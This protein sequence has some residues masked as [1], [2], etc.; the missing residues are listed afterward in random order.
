MILERLSVACWRSILGEVVLGPLE[1]R[2]NLVSAPNGSGK[3]SLFEALQRGIFD[4]HQVSGRSMEEIRPW[5]RDLAPR[6]CIEFSHDGTGYRLTKQFLNQAF[7]RLERREQGRFQPFKQGRRADE[8]VRGLFSDRSPGR[9]LS[10]PEH[11]GLLQVLWAPQ[12]RVALSD[13]S[14]TVVT[15][16]KQALGVQLSA[17][18]GGPIEEEIARRYF[19]FFTRTGKVR[20]GRNAPELV[21]L[22]A[23]LQQLRRQLEQL[24]EQRRA[25]E[26]A[27]LELERQCGLRQQAATEAAGLSRK[28][29]EARQRQK[30]FEQVR[31]ELQNARSRAVAAEAEYRSLEER[32]RRL[33]SATREVKELDGQIGADRQKLELAQEEIACLEK[34]AARRRAR[35]EDLE[36]EKKHL[37]WLE[38]RATMGLRFVRAGD[39]LESLTKRLEQIEKC[40]RKLEVARQQRQGLVAPDRDTLK[41]VRRMVERCSRLEARIQGAMVHLEIDPCRNL[42]V[43]IV[44]GEGDV[45]RA[46]EGRPVTISGPAEVVVEL[47]GLARLRATGPAADLEKQQRDLE[48]TRRELERLTLPYGTADPDKLQQLLFRAEKLDARIAE[49]ERTRSLLLEDGDIQHLRAGIAEYKGLVNGALEEF[50]AWKDSPADPD[51][52]KEEYEEA[53]RAYEKRSTDATAAYEQARREL[54]A[55][56]TG[57][58][59]LMAGLEAKQAERNRA[60]ERLAELGQ[61]GQSLGLLDERRKRLALEW[62]AARA[63]IKDLEKRLQGFGADPGEELEDLERRLELALET[64]RRARDREKTVEGRVS[65]LAGQGI[66]GRIAACQEKISILEDQVERKRLEMDGVALLYRTVNELRSEL[67]ASVARPLEDVASGLMKR[68]G[69]Y[70]A[71]RVRLADDLAPAYIEP[72]LADQPVGLENLSGGENEQ[73]HFVCRLALAEVLARDQRQLL[74]LDDVLTATDTGRLMRILRILDEL[75]NK[76]QIVILTC[77]PERYAALE[78]AAFF[79]LEKLL[80]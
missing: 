6:V 64:E 55:A 41:K 4:S 24:E 77:H 52:L 39:G 27:R 78:G 48:R 54:Q 5:G 43:E 29:K 57:L 32:I 16:V 40:D 47:A 61:D 79:D 46:A 60:R 73:L 19:A 26:D 33:N 21:A 44:K 74:V 15:S 9:G 22:E 35:L 68:I 72:A 63:P 20:G 8:F 36:K 80:A 45:K 17:A 75:A 51:L 1:E 11:H 25:L 3:S 71:G 12:G 7:A 34:A 50:P 58:Q 28:V 31:Q 30:Q 38:K 59:R 42:E 10:K 67:T 2:I 76:L 53:R 69:W 62:D 13:L 14:A 23:E 70:P 18:A 37:E 66:Y 49:L 65:Q 56:E